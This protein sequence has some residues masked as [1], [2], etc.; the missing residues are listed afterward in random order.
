MGDS[1]R[2]AILR[3][4]GFEVVGTVESAGGLLPEQAWRRV[5]NLDVVPVAEVDDDDLDRVDAE[6]RGLADESGLFADDGSFLISPPGPG[7]MRLPWVRVRLTA[8]TK[9]AGQLHASPGQPEFVTAALDGHV[10]LGVTSEE[11]GVWLVR[12]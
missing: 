5:I 6:W 10:V 7:A 12:G 4:A 8:A 9:L 2:A 11:H 3:S 1:G